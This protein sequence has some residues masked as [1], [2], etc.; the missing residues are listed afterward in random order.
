MSRKYQEI[1]ANNEKI[2]GKVKKKKQTFPKVLKINKKSL[3]SSEQISDNLNSFFPLLK[4]FRQ[5][6]QV[7]LNT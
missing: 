6:Q 2:A 7:T 4:I 1:M 5:S 3:Y